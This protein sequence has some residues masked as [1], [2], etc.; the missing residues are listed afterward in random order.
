[1]PSLNARNL[2][3]LANQLEVTKSAGVFT[4]S[5]R[6]ANALHEQFT[7]AGVSVGRLGKGSFTVSENAIDAVPEAKPLLNRLNAM[8]ASEQERY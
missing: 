1:M 5:G 4:I 2:G 6:S 3:L 7:D 8:A